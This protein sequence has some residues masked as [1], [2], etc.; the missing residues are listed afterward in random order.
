MSSVV[1]TLPSNAEVGSSSFGQGTKIP[2]A[3]PPKNQNV[4]NKSNIVTNS[5][6]N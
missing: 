6:K 2:Y 4:K 3:L 1:K 5:M